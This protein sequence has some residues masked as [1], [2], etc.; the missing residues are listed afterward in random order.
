MIQSGLLGLSRHRLHP[1]TPICVTAGR[2]GC[3]GPWTQRLLARGHFSLKITGESALYYT[4][5]QGGNILCPPA[6][7]KG[8]FLSAANPQRV[9]G[10]HTWRQVKAPD[11]GLKGGWEARLQQQQRVDCFSSDTFP[12][13]GYYWALRG[14]KEV[15]GRM[16]SILEIWK[17][18]YS[19]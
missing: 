4:D 17:A 13:C 12:S 3:P 5:V 19:Y 2:A 16:E 11:T 7:M 1:A 14:E 18:E 15:A 10:Q 8:P 9:P 6:K